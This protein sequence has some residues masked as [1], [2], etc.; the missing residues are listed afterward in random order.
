MKVQSGVR[1]FYMDGILKSNMD[2][3]VKQVRSDWDMVIAVDGV[4]GSGKSTLAAQCCAY[5][6]PSFN[7][8]RITFTAN[9]FKQAIMDAEKYQAVVFDE[10]F[11]GLS[12]RG[13]MTEVNRSLV[14]MLAEIRQK[15][16]FVFI[17]LPTFFDLDRNIAIWRSRFLIHVYAHKGERGRFTFYNR[18]KKKQL[19]ILG[20]K[21][22]NYGKPKASF[23]GRFTNY[24]P[25]DNDAYRKKKLEALE[26]Y[27]EKVENKNIH[28][29][30]LCKL[31]WYLNHDLNIQQKEMAKA[32]ETTV[33]SIKGMLR[34][35]KKR[36]VMCEEA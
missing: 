14:S 5:V 36:G 16:L 12:S 18:N 17:V 24:S 30:R 10:G 2:L 33:D 29:E 22:Y 26:R 3:C 19:Y 21:L 32:M 31:I 13:A 23:Y 1:E 8:N 27:T 20:K 4:E 28:K 9:D 6:D 35:A 25:V 15:N 7:I 11:Q 34:D